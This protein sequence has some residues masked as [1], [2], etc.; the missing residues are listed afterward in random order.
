MRCRDGI[1]WQAAPGRYSLALGT[2]GRRSGVRFG[3]NGLADG[4][5]TLRRWCHDIVDPDRS[6][7]TTKLDQTEV[8]SGRWHRAPFLGLCTD[9]EPASSPTGHSR[10]TS[11]SP[12]L[13]PR[14]CDTRNFGVDE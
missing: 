4:L 11:A 3:N 14:A 6:C 5:R 8:P 7:G 2:R 10:P 13:Y 1:G 9:I 12:A